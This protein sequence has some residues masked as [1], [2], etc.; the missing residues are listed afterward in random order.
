MRL[1][2]EERADQAAGRL[3][4][5]PGSRLASRLTSVETE[6][7]PGGR[8]P[9]RP[10]TGKGEHVRVKSRGGGESPVTPPGSVFEST[11]TN[12]Q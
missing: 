4:E 7:I 2:R 3:P 8:A 6:P 12:N 5:R 9:L 1:V 10:E 11:A